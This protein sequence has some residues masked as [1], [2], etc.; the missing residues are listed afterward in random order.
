[1]VLQK[2]AVKASTRYQL[3]AYIK[4]QKVIPEKKG[5]SGWPNC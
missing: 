2:V 5:Q 4:T 3:S 1:M